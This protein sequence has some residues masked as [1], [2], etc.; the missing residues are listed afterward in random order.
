MDKTKRTGQ[1]MISKALCRK[2]K[3]E[4]HEFGG[5]R[6]VSSCW[7]TSVAHCVT[8]ITN[9][10]IIPQWGKDRIVIRTNRTYQWSFNL[11]D[12][13]LEN[14]QNIQYIKHSKYRQDSE[15]SNY[16]FYKSVSYQWSFTRQIFHNSEPSHCGNCK[17]SKCRLQL[18]QK[19]NLCFSSLV[20]IRKHL[21]RKP[22]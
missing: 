4:Q 17:L 6:M 22:W 19:G 16:C 1:I 20:A 12:I 5:S 14:N 13:Y 18:D 15:T 21:S 11:N 10:V 3:I 8:L 9:Q 7:S 2:L